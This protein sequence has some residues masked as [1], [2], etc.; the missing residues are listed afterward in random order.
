MNQPRST[1]L[2]PWPLAMAAFSR[3][4][5]ERDDLLRLA[6]VPVILVFLFYL[7]LQR[8]TEATFMSMSPG[9]QPDPE[10]LQALQGPVMLYGIGSWCITAV[11]TANWMRIL[12]L[13]SGA[14]GGLGLSLGRR[15]LRIL[16]LS[17]GLQVLAGVLLTLTLFVV[18]MVAPVSAVVFAVMI[19]FMIWYVIVVMRLCPVWVGIAID[20]PMKLRDAWART[21]GAGIRLA[22]SVLIVSAA[23]IVMQLLFFSLSLTL[24]VTAAAPL[25]L[26]FIS[27][28]VQFVMFAAIGAVFVLAYPRFV[29]ETV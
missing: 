8:S 5:Q 17:I 25:A 20:A 2:Q 10:T 23:L 16:I 13:G 7:W 24:G 11:F 6:A 12:M 3:V 9:Q 21:D 4:W 28:A 29:S 1:D 22:V 19:L 14:V 18:I 27:V 26:S 15:H